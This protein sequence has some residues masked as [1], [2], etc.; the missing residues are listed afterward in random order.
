MDQLKK[1][2]VIPVDNRQNGKTRYWFVEHKADAT[3]EY[4][5][6]IRM[7]L[8]ADI[9]PTTP[10]KVLKLDVSS[11]EGGV[12]IWGAVSPVYDTT[13][14]TV[15]HGIH[16]HA[17]RSAKSKKEIDATYHTV[18]VSGMQK[19]R[20]EENFIISELDA[21]YHMVASI[22]GS[23]MKYM[24]CTFCG[25][26]HLDKDW[27]CVHAHHIH[28]CAGC[29]RHFQDTDRGIGNPIIKIREVFGR[30]IH[31]IRSPQRSIQIQQE[32]Y[33]GGIQ[34][35][36]SHPAIIWTADRDEEEGIHIHAFND[37]DKIVIDNTYSSV[38]IDGISL[39]PKLVRIFMAQKALPHLAGRITHIQCPE[40]HE[41]HFDIG[42]HSF[43]PHVQHVCV[44]CG[45]RFQ[46][47]GRIRKTVGNPIIRVLAQLSE[48]AP[49]A[50]H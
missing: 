46:T 15:D 44:N 14:Q 20:S 42:E 2:E 23:E 19:D 8:N 12:A 25:F 30:C 11:Y 21:I 9:P 33:P 36:G 43:T 4:C 41:S 6:R 31:K 18:S 1:C 37:N 47:E 38:T 22:L 40:C 45:L 29:G 26:P 10:D 49:R 27:F 17:R 50:L 13:N 7:C 16:V 3:A 35:W 5:R 34:I 24:E 28:L 39:D 48:N 32:D